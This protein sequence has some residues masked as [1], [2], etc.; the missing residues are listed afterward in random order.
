[1]AEIA[2]YLYTASIIMQQYW[3]FKIGSDILN[4]DQLMIQSSKICEIGM[5]I[6]SK[7]SDLDHPI[8]DIIYTLYEFSRPQGVQKSLCPLPDAALI[9]PYR[10]WS[11]R[12]FSWSFQAIRARC[13][14]ASCLARS[15]AREPVSSAYFFFNTFSLNSSLPSTQW[16]RR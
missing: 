3:Y 1:M 7:W 14:S 11:S 2:S 12:W 4:A 8:G 15:S 10:C 13:S 5:P 9:A 6:R 16:T